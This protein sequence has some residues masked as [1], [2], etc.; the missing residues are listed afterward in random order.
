MEKI[1]ILHIYQNS[2]IG[3]IQQQLLSVL[4][5]YDKEVFN[6]IFCCFRHKGEIGKEIERMGIEVIAFNRPRYYKFSIG[7]DIVRDLYRLIKQKNI[8]VA[9]SHRYHANL[10]GRVAARLADVPVIVSSVHDNYRMDKRLKRRIINHILSKIS[11]KI[12]AVSESIKKD[13][14][15]YDKIDTSKILVIPNSVDIERFN[16]EGNFAN[17]KE[18]FL[19]KNNDIVIGFVGRIV[20]A[21]GLEYLI[22][23]LS[24]L[25]EEFR[26]IKLLIIGEGSLVD[27]LKE[28]SKE[29]NVN[30]SVIFT[31]R[32]R[33][34]H[35]ILSCIDI[36]VMPSIAE[37]LPNALLEA[38]AMAK[39][40][41]AT[42]VGGI[43]E[44]IKNG[45]N[46]LLVP[47]RN[48]ESITTA[49]KTLLAD[50]HLTTKM[51]QRARNYV[52]ENL[53]IQATVR[54]WESLYI[55]LLKEKG[56]IITR[57]IEQHVKPQM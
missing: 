40:I 46:G 56:V 2:N 26:N 48:A 30:D 28:K 35:D 52:E 47:P 17:I 38:M 42:E 5:S 20:P 10:Y 9:R 15:I 19:I 18:E 32:R 55:S 29:N 6:P 1:N 33:D 51:G 24:Y 8:Q 39:P 44:V 23:T 11:D 49:I 13:I 7:I 4:K 54:K 43:P 16:P 53:S 14:V 3:G 37:G 34:I 50:M 25:K 57:D 22:D 45:I 21:K 31:G 36:F 12:I 41:V 27:G